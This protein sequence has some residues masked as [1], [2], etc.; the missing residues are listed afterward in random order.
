MAWST[1]LAFS[2]AIFLLALTPGPDTA[3]TLRWTLL[4]GRRAGAAVALGSMTGVTVHL[5]AAALGLS[6]LLA[7]SAT[8]FT[9]VKIVGAVYLAFLGVRLLLHRRHDVAA[10]APEKRSRLGRALPDTPYAQGAL[11]GIT[12]PKTAL[13]FLTLLPQFVDVRHADLWALPVLAVVALAIMAVYWAGFLA[14]VG[15]ARSAVRRP[16]VQAAIERVTGGVFVALAVRLVAAA[17]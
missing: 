7:A 11:S 9:V 10:A 8:A 5:T 15:G 2:G 13:F 16:R 4:S 17:R 6:T 1:L 3:L 12:N 14:L